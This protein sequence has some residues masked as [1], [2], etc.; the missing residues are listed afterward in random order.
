[1]IIGP[2]AYTVIIAFCLHSTRVLVS[3]IGYHTVHIHKNRHRSSHKDLPAT[4]FI[5]SSRI[6][7]SFVLAPTITSTVDS[8]LM[9]PFYLRIYRC[10]TNT[11]GNE[12]D[13][14]FL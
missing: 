2:M 9:Q 10:C 4:A 1:M 6:N 8:V 13:P 11:A 3:L 5:S 12:K 14:F 7:R